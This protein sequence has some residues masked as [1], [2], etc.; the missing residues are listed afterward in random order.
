MPNSNHAKDK[1]VKGSAASE[2]RAKGAGYRDYD[3]A[4]AFALAQMRGR[5]E[6]DAAATAEA[7]R[8]RYD[9]MNAF[10]MT[11]GGLLGYVRDKYLAATGGKK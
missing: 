5:V 2:A 1:R 9:P 6:A 8:R 7:K 10:N 3:Q 4:R 11:G